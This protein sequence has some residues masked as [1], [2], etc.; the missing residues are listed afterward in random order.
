MSELSDIKKMLKEHIEFTAEINQKI[1]DEQVAQ[2][3]ELHRMN[4]VLI[5]DEKSGVDGLAQKVMKN[6]KYIS[7][8]KKT[9]WVFFGSVGVGAGGLWAYIKSKFGI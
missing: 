4:F 7:N 6:S 8:D 1:L 9:K 5:G 2:R 3:T